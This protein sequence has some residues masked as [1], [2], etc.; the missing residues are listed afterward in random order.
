MRPSP[1]PN[2]ST[3]NPVALKGR[4]GK[5]A[6]KDEFGDSGKN[7]RLCRAFGRTDITPLTTSHRQL[8]A[9]EGTRSPSVEVPM[10]PRIGILAF[11]IIVVAP[12]ASAQIITTGSEP[13]QTNT[14]HPCTLQVSVEAFPFQTITD[15]PYSFSRTIQRVTT[16]ADGTRIT[17][18][19]RVSKMFRDSAGRARHEFVVCGGPFD[20]ADPA[21]AVDIF[22]VVGG[23]RYA[24]DE[25]NQ[26]A[27]RIPLKGLPVIRKQVQPSAK[28]VQNQTTETMKIL[29]HESLGTQVME[30]LVVDGYRETTTTPVNMIGNDRPIVTVYERWHSK[31]IDMDVLTKRD[32]PRNGEDT[33]QLSN[34]SRNEPDPALFQPP[35]GYTIVD[36]TSNFKIVF[37]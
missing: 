24:L 26:I 16:L 14:Q 17:E 18:K 15:K 37:R 29:P 4:I 7:V 9:M 28:Q 11:L 32:D 13:I 27:Y 22:D 36:E 3:A 10:K 31:D 20:D 23:Y 25:H 12:S 21:V 2:A 5:K 8:D 30:G 6:Q 1:Q 19:P 34:I 35:P 33:V